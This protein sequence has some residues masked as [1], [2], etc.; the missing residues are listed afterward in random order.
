M[1]KKIDFLREGINPLIINELIYT[2]PC[3]QY[4]AGSLIFKPGDP[5]NTI[6]MIEEGVVEIFIYFEGTKFIIER[7]F[8]GS[9]INYRNLFLDDEPT[10]VYAQALKLSFII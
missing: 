8:P 10:Q 1:L 6:Q 7:L 9:V 3:V 4:E 2:T 5:M